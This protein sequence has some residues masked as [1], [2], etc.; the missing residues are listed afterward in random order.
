LFFHKELNHYPVHIQ[1]QILHGGVS[2]GV[3]QIDIDNGVL[4]LAVLPTRGMNIQ[5]AECGNVQ[6]KWNSPNFGPVHPSFVPLYDPSGFGWLE[7][8]TEWFVRCGLESNG[9]PDFSSG[10]QLVHPLHGRIANIP[11]RNITLNVNEA[12]GGITLCGKVYETRLFFK[13]L[14]LDTSITTYAGSSR[15]TVTDKITN[16]SAHGGE[17]ELLY[18][19]NTGQPFASPGSR[20]C[21]PFNRM[22]PRSNAAA[23]NLP[24]WNIL[25]PEMPESEEVVFFFEP[26]ADAG[27]LCKVLLVN[28]QGNEALQLSFRPQQL[29][30]FCFWKSRLSDKDGYV[31]GLEPAVNFPNPKSFEKRHGRV[32]PLQPGETKTFELTFDIFSD[33]AAVQKAEDAIKAVSAGAVIEQVPR[34]DW[35]A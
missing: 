14:E 27:G 16:L 19:I 34:Q 20:I 23:E 8:F 31:C 17:F 15:F 32:V 3:E 4:R 18:H 13:K 24:Q 25:D 35:S 30:Y 2:E 10:G 12:T 6:L 22:A 33:A 21:L 11:A 1:K 5:R 29:P 26:A 7:G 9:S 28:T